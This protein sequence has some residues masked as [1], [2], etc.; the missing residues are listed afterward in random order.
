MGSG[1]TFISVFGFALL[2]IALVGMLVSQSNHRARKARNEQIRQLILQQRRL[3]N[4][5]RSLPP[6]YLS[7]ELRDFIYQALQQNIKSQIT[8][9]KDKNDLLKDDYEQITAERERV[10]QN[11]PEAT[12]LRLTA[13]QASI[14]R[15]LLKSLYQFIRRNYET[16]R[17]NKSHAEK[18]IK[19]VEIKLVETAVDF[20]ELTAKEFYSE[21]KFRQARNS[22]QKALNA[23][24]ESVYEVQFKQRAVE[25]RNTM[26]KMV[27]EWRESREEVS[28]AASEKLA[29]GM[30]SYVEEQDSWK[31]KQHYE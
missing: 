1:M 4:L 7:L 9:T 11:P 6:S 28:K 2:A 14:Y 16:G 10:K 20:F 31:K 12:A 22:Y 23:I 13:D 30:E 27:S 5:L 24:D 26:N 19:Q 18:I 29:G 8:L 21:K 25:L 17:L 3:N 15:G